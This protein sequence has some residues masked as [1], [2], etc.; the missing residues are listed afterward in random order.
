MLLETKTVRALFVSSAQ[1]TQE[2][3]VLP[4]KEGWFTDRSYTE[5]NEFVLDNGMES[6]LP[7]SDPKE[8]LAAVK[9]DPLYKGENYRIVELTLTAKLVEHGLLE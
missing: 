1:G 7:N 3:I 2:Y 9:T 4:C 5:D 6:S 8:L